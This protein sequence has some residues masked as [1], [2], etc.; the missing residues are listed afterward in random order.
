LTVGSQILMVEER[1]VRE[2]SRIPAKGSRMIRRLLTVIA[3]SLAILMLTS[4]AALAHFCFNASRPANAT[5][6]AAKTAAWLSL[7]ELLHFLV[8]EGVLPSLCDDG[9][10]YIVEQVD[11]NGEFAT[12]AI[13]VLASG[14]NVNNP[15]LSGNN[16]GIDH[17]LTE[18]P[19][20]PGHPEMVEAVF[21]AVPGALAE[22]S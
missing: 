19:D 9:I 11:P 4:T 7:E 5:Q 6:N 8:D 21:S 22:C 20:Y 16:Q 15:Q 3:G 2:R 1:D 17:L 14:Q 13:V 18:S 12:H 10:D